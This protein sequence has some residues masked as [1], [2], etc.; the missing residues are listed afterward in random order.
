[1]NET[2][3]HLRVK[4]YSYSSSRASF[5]EIG[6]VHPRL[7]DT[8]CKALQNNYFSDINWSW[9]STGAVYAN[10]RMYLVFKNNNTFESNTLRI[11]MAWLE[12]YFYERDIE[13]KE[14]PS[15]LKELI[16]TQGDD[17]VHKIP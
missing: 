8:F 12:E 15:L 11:R 5:K 6:I 17:V 13:G 14:I 3:L 9:T 4:A 10:G 2:D 7:F 16:R 1:M